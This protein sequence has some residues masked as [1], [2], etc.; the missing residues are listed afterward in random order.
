MPTEARLQELNIRTNTSEPCRCQHVNKELVAF[1]SCKCWNGSFAHTQQPASSKHTNLARVAVK[2][3]LEGQA[4]ARCHFECRRSLRMVVVATGHD[5]PC[6]RIPGRR[7]KTLCL[8]CRRAAFKARCCQHPN[9]IWLKAWNGLDVLL[10]AEL[11]WN[12]Q[13]LG[14]IAC[15]C[16]FFISS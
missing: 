6:L 14:N 15:S 5:A 8:L 1:K 2:L 3:V 7:K 9:P 12:V 10:E 4:Q 11:S 13:D 16:C